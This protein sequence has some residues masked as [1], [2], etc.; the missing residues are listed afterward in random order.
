LREITRYPCGNDE[1]SNRSATQ[2][3]VEFRNTCSIRRRTFDVRDDV[4]VEHAPRGS[5]DRLIFTEAV[6]NDWASPATA[7]RSAIASTA[8][9]FR[10]RASSI[11]AEEAV[12]AGAGEPFDLRP[13][14]GAEEVAVVLLRPDPQPGAG[15][16]EVEAALCRHFPDIP[17]EAVAA[18][19]GE[20]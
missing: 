1:A 20:A 10:T 9:C 17:E 15:A 2:G 12:A 16:A 7:P 13:A 5:G 8:R 3:P 11:S 6:S 19:A 4:T 14:A 18:G